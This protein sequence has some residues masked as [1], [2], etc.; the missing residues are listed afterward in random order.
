MS[1]VTFPRTAPGPLVTLDAPLPEKR[2]FTLLD[3]ARIVQNEERW[4]AGAFLN[5]YPDGRPEALDPCA[6]GT[7]RVKNTEAGIAMPLAGSFTVVIGGTCTGSG[8]GSTADWYKTRLKAAFVA[9]EAETVERVLADGLPGSDLGSYL[10]DENMETLGSGAVT[11]TEGLALLEREIATVGNGTI[12]VAP[13]T[14]T[15]WVAEHLIEAASRGGTI[16]MRTKLGTLVVIGAGYTGVVPDGK[17][18]PAADQEWAFASSMIQVRREVDA[19]ILPS[20]YSQALDRST[21]EVAFYAERAYLLNWIGRQD[22][23]DEAHIQAGVLIDR[24]P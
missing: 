9:V 24:T 14:A 20:E 18:V 19:T 13:A 4:Q 23:S 17:A 6:E 7:N 10:G 8:I 21:N 2:D 11:P 12:H 1:T 5:G 22:T 16:Q 15:Y 3:A